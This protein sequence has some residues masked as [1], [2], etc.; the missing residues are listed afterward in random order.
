MRGFSLVELSIVLVILGLL[1]GEILAGQ[2]LI[3]A[4]ELRAVG[5]EFSRYQTAG[6]A[7]R[8]KYFALPGDMANAT[9]V[10]GKDAA[11]C[12]TQSGNAGAP[13][14]CNGDGD[15]Y[16]RDITTGPGTTTESMQFWKQLSLAGL[17]EGTFTGLSGPTAVA[18][19]RTGADAR[20]GL[21]IPAS[22]LSSAGWGLSASSATPYAGFGTGEF[23]TPITYDNFLVF[24][25]ERYYPSGGGYG[26][27]NME[28]VLKP[29]EAWNID[30]KLDD[31]TPAGGKII[32]IWWNNICSSPNS[33]GASSTNIDASYRLSER[34]RTCAL[35]FRQ[36]F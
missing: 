34:N 16:V 22:K 18:G 19:S 20:V 23:F 30:T 12:N 35:I 9:S 2:S 1:V 3:R 32:G 15:G 36:A 17:V 31:G 26:V 27:Y 5:A 8:D 28:R 25:A 6:H 10:W 33:G 21:N 11:A 29:E 13:G 24:G 14:T 4:S 7:F